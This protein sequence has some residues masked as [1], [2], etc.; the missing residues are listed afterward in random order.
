MKHILIL[1]FLSSLLSARPIEPSPTDQQIIS[2]TFNEQFDQAKKLCQEQINSNPNSPKYYYYLINT[3]MMEYYQKVSELDP[4]KRDEARKILNKEIIDYC[5]KVLERFDESKL[6]TENKFYYGTIY[7]YLAR[8]YG[9]DASWWSAF[10]SGKKAK[11]TMQ[12]ILKADSL[13][14]DAYLILGML[15]YY[16][17]RMSGIT[18]FIA[19]VLGLSGDRDIGLN[20]LKI[21]YEKGS[22]TFGQTALTLIEAYSSLEGNETAALPYFEGFLNRYPKNKRTLNAYCRTLMNLWNIKKVESIIKSDKDNL[23][24][25]YT[26]ARFYDL[27]GNSALAIQ[28]GEMA[29]QNER[30]LYRGGGNA[31]RHII[32]FNS[33]LAGD[34]LKMNKYEPTLTER[35]KTAFAEAK[36]FEKETKWLRELTIQIAADK[37]V[38][39]IENYSKSKPDFTSLKGFED[40]YNILI[41]SFYFKNNVYDKSEYYFNRS[42]NSPDD[43]GRYTAA[44]YLLD[45]YMKQTVDKTKVKNLLKII[46]NIDNSRLSYR[47][48]DLE[49]K[50][51]L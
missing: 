36:K 11:S 30:K 44:R 5:E 35:Y 28:Y 8:I 50:Y 37:P 48:K 19:G 4:E 16:A 34:Y 46:D 40:E 17:D 7:A 45:L 23:V 13:F 20:Y 6:N 49:K 41:G 9:V 27:T 38:S 25:D 42:I 21:S 43:R 39:A 22:L 3:K 15:E 12:D 18:S 1:V 47:S 32:V 51:N 14:Y 29:L 2:Y 24:D 33:W 26:K 31:A 10:K